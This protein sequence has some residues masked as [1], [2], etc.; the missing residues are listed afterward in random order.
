MIT[1][2]VFGWILFYGFRLNMPT[3]LALHIPDGFLSLPVSLVTWA[4]A[5]ALIALSLNRVNAE[6][7]E[8]TVP[9]M[10]VCAAFISRFLAEPLDIFWAA[11]WQG[12]CWDPGQ[13]PWS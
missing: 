11:H 4:I 3:H 5:I 6:Y 2:Q 9:L 12:F 1:G 10:G 13:E 7:Q 8:R